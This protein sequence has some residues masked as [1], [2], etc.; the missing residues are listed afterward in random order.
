MATER[1]PQIGPKMGA[2]R[3]ASRAPPRS[4]PGSPP[5]FRG[6]QR[7]LQIIDIAIL[8]FPR[9][10]RHVTSETMGLFLISGARW[11]VFQTHLDPSGLTRDP[12]PSSRFP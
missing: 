1:E 6:S 7:V 12:G 3:G 11:N 4:P 2:P 9:Y 10:R 8:R 5:G